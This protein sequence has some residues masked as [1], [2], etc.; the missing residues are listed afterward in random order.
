MEHPFAILDEN[1]E[2][3]R[4]VKYLIS[5]SS[6]G[7]FTSVPG[8]DCLGQPEDT[9]VEFMPTGVRNTCGLEVDWIVT[10]VSD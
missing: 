6:T 4:R 10:V 2:A 5:V 7:G 9:V 8:D 1:W 3:A